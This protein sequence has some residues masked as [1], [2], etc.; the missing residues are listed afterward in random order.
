MPVFAV[1]FVGPEKDLSA[2]YGPIN[3]Q[4]VTDQPGIA[5]VVIVHMEFEPQP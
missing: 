3:S 5:Q 2:T 1:Q 4:P